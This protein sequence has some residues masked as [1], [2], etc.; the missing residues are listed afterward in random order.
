MGIGELKERLR[1]LRAE[2][3][4]ERATVAAGASTE[5]PMRIRELKRAIAR[6]LTVIRE[7]QIKEQ[8]SKKKGKK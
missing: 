7:E 2:L 3:A 6:V 1:E 5:N 4:R 8:R